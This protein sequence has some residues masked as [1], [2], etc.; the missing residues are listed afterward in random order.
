MKP[1]KGLRRIRQYADVIRMIID[2]AGRSGSSQE[3]SSLFILRFQTP[4]SLIPYTIIPEV[5]FRIPCLYFSA[6]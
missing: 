2:P 4:N 1:L 3:C 6:C 5:I